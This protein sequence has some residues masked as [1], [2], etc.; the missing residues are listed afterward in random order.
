MSSL[1]QE[2]EDLGIGNKSNVSDDDHS[3]ETKQQIKKAWKR[4]PMSNVNITLPVALL[5]LNTTEYP[6]LSRARR[7]IRKDSILIAPSSCNQN[8][9]IIKRGKVD[10]RTHPFDIISK[11]VCMSENKNVCDG[12]L[13]QNPNIPIIVQYQDN[14]IAVIN[15]PA[16]A[17]VIPSRKDGHRRQTVQ[18]ALPFLLKPPQ[19]FPAESCYPHHCHRLD[20]PTSGLLVCAK[21]KPALVSMSHLFESHAVDK[22]HTAIINGVP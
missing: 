19:S 7:E 14:H 16:G 22:T 8:V 21:T 13:C 3:D 9:T 6:T 5:L 10:D 1:S 2:D 12:M 11:Q 4:N 20:M 17:P 15:K 18:A